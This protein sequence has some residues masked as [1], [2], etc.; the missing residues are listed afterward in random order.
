ME[1][2]DLGRLFS[3]YIRTIRYSE[4]NEMPEVYGI[5]DARLG[6]SYAHYGVVELAR[7]KRPTILIIDTLIHE[8]G[9]SIDP[10][11]AGNDLSSISL[12]D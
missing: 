10:R 3:R 5:K 2:P 11:L 1:G 8:W 6:G 4:N 9:H 7:G 12:L